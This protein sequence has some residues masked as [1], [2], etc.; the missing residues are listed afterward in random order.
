MRGA[1]YFGAEV[2]RPRSR[3]WNVDHLKDH[4]LA[5][6]FLAP[7][8][9]VLLLIVGWPIVFSFFLSLH[10]VAISRGELVYQFDKLGNYASL[11]RDA[12]FQQALGQTVVYTALRVASVLG[13]GMTLAQILNR[14]G[15]GAAVFKRIFLLPWALPYVVNALMWGWVFNGAWGVFNAVLLKLGIISEYVVWLAH[16]RWAMLVIIFAS[17]WK[18]VPFAALML[19]AALKTVPSELEDAAKV[20]GAGAWARFRHI[21]IPWIK[22]VILVLLIIETMWA[23][24]TFDVIW[25]LTEGRPMDKTMVLN[26]LTY[27]LAFQ[28]F[29]LGYASA[30]AYIITGLILV[31]TVV[32]FRLLGGLEN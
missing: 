22:P 21:I 6:V 13:I 19:L 5:L 7:S 11:L 28:F 14:S 27:Q 30:L 31:L 17:V 25:V 10:K 29:R 15:V 1:E 18:A 32:Y 3:L 9:S 23:L 4:Q 16:P 12:R 26:V 24:K 2:W 8:L 20:D